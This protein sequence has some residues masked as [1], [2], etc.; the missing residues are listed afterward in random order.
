MSNYMPQEKRAAMRSAVL[1]SAAL[2][3]LTEGY[4]K[5]TLCR[6]SKHSGVQ[7]SAINRE[8]R[9]KGNI[10]CALIDHVVNGQFTTARKL[11]DGITKDPVLY[12][13]LETVLQ[14]HI[15][16]SSPAVKELYIIAYLL[17]ESVEH[18]RRSAVERLIKPSF[19]VYLPD[20]EDEDIYLLDVATTGIMLS[21]MS[22][23]CGEK[24]PIAVKTRHYLEASLRVYRVPEEKIREAAAFTEQFDLPA[25]A[26]QTIQQM[27][28]ALENTRAGPPEAEKS[29]VQTPGIQMIPV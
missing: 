20:A 24:F 1:H 18:I 26:R 28:A 23:A 15:A 7:I 21:H 4:A 29:G 19:S 13:A 3:F 22:M 5:T 2:L 17:P 27:I 10:L 6:I 9:G 16:E 14:L 8:F 25:I 12:Y 11:M